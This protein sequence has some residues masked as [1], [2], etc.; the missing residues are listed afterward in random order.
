M[1]NEEGRLYKTPVKGLKR[2]INI[3]SLG[4]EVKIKKSFGDFGYFCRTT[5]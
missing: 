2:T 1:P 5:P 4:H 3:V